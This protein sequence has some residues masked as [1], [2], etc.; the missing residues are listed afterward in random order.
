MV[1]KLPL[2]EDLP[3]LARALPELNLELI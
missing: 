2:L 3:L 1:G